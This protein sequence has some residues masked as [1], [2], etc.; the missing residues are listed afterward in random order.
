MNTQDPSVFYEVHPAYA[1]N[2]GPPRLPGESHQR[3][4]CGGNADLCGWCWEHQLA[5]HKRSARKLA[6]VTRLNQGSAKG[7]LASGG[8]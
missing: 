5:W 1:R 3:G 6:K 7:L 2:P 4:I 8:W